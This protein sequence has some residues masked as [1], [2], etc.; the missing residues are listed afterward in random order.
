[1][2]PNLAR[3]ARR[4]SCSVARVRGSG[5]GVE[6]LKLSFFNPSRQYTESGEILEGYLSISLNGVFVRNNVSQTSHACF[7]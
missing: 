1:V 2:I 5:I 7:P 6:M 4:I 3:P